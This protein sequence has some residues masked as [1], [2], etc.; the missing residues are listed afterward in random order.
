MDQQQASKLLGLIG[1]ESPT[2]ITKAY[3]IKVNALEEKIDGAPTDVLKSKFEQMKG[4]LSQAHDLLLTS[5]QK[6]TMASSPLSQTKMADLPGAGPN[7]AEASVNLNEGTTLAGRYQIKEQIGAGGMGAVYRAFDSNTEKDIALKVL[8]PSLLKNERARERFMDEARISQQLSHPNIVNVFDVQHDG[9]YYFLTMELLEG[10]DL[11]QVMENRTLARQP[12]AVDEVQEIIREVSLGLANAHK[13]TVHRDIKPENIWLS[14]QGEYKIMDFGIA[15]V[16]STSQRTQTGAAMGT[17]YYMAPEQLKGQANIDGRADQ[18]AL[19]V[20]AYELLTGEVPAGMIEPVQTHRKDTPK[21]MAKAIH[22]GLASRP[23]NRFANITAF[24]EAITSGKSGVSMPNL[25]LKGIGIAAAIV[26]AV[27]GIGSVAMNGGLDSIWQAIKPV[28]KALIAQQQAAIAKLQGEI[29]NY[30]KR[31]EKGQRNLK[32]DVRDAERNNSR[33]LKYVQHWQRLTEDYLF[34]GNDL[35]ELEGELS[36]GV[37]L[38]RQGQQENSPEI[39]KQ[40]TSTLTQVRD[41]YKHLWAQFNAAENVLMAEE[42]SNSAFKQWDKR[43]KA[44][45]L[46]TPSQASDATQIEE[47]AK[48]SQREGDFVGALTDWQAATKQWQGAY[49]VMSGEVASIDSQRSRDKKAREKK[50]IRLAQEKAD[51]DKADRDKAARLAQEKAARDKAARDKAARLAQEKAIKQAVGKMVSIP[52]GSFLMGS[53]EDS[54]EKPIHRVSIRAFKMSQT[55]VTFAQWDAC[56]SAGGC[57]HKPKDEGWGR[58]SRPVMNVSFNDITQQFIPWL[59]KVTGNTYR[60]PTEAEWEYAAR[61]G[62]SSKYSWGNNISCSQARY[63]HWNGDC[64]NESKTVKVKSYSANGFGLY[65]MHGNVWE[66]TQDCWNDSYNSAPNSGSAWTS[67]DCARRVLRGGS[68]F[69]EPNFLRSAYR[70]GFSAASRFYDSGFRL[71]QGR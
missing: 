10:Q 33:E 38:A 52:S 56:V 36:K 35:T 71:V 24:S 53:N 51:R 32:S 28:D 69:Y 27:L 39:I 11:R 61:A 55:E 58:G 12:F 44:Y 62:S 6:N 63:G 5:S 7:E 2:E 34:D 49:R 9:D 25:P 48:Q 47:Q 26:V 68:W 19:S 13:V 40:A 3:Q 17:A 16:Q 67:G 46:D 50:A 45:N 70:Y 37:N 60:L 59:N 20:L 29:K 22:I 4:S 66:W 18:Y 1:G 54:D 64:G 42:Q 43:K 57:S 41:G 15:R 8:L 23:E 30:Q 31:L 65:D 14:E 21:S